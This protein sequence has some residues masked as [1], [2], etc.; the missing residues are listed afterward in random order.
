MQ[1]GFEEHSLC[2]GARYGV[3]PRIL[4]QLGSHAFD[5]LGRFSLISVFHLL[6]IMIPYV[7]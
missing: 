7:R 4:T 3:E 6:I 2:V 1:V 5:S